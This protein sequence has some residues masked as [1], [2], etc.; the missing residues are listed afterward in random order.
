MEP[1]PSKLVSLIFDAFSDLNI[2]P[3]QRKYFNDGSGMCLDALSHLCRSS[4]NGY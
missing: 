1:A 2:V 3:L 4:S